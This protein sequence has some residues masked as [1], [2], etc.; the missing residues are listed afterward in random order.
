MGEIICNGDCLNCIY[1]DCIAGRNRDRINEYQRVYRQ[2]N[3]DKFK[4]YE[5]DRYVKNHANEMC[6]RRLSAILGMKG[7]DNGESIQ[8]KGSGGNARNQTKDSKA[9]D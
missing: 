8:A 5:H 9:V 3:K 4:K 6:R 1:D 7:K 2:K